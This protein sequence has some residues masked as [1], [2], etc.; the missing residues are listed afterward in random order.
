MDK[1]WLD[2]TIA[3]NKFCGE[4]QTDGYRFSA[5]RNILVY[6]ALQV[7]QRTNCLI[8]PLHDFMVVKA[9]AQ[10]MTKINLIFNR[11]RKPYMAI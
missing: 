3:A 8:C 4:K 6:I 7:A 1:N 10:K 5:S 11:I 9:I 2:R